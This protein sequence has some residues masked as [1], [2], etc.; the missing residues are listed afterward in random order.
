MSISRP[1]TTSNLFALLLA[2]L[3]VLVLQA[4]LANPVPGGSQPPTDLS[5]PSQPTNTTQTGQG[6]IL[7]IREWPYLFGGVGLLVGC[8]IFVC[9]CI[10]FLKSACY[11]IVILVILC[12]GGEYFVH[13]SNKRSRCRAPWHWHFQPHPPSSNHPA[14]PAER[15]LLSRC[16]QDMPTIYAVP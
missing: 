14:E 2:C 15:S 1:S 13:F 3:L 7:D 9:C 11:C 8:L 10:S 12:I 5:S 6:N 4:T 16:V